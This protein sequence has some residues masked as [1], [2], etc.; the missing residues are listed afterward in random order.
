LAA[1][2]KNKS[3]GPDKVAGKILTLGGE[4]MISCLARLLGVTINKASIPSK[5]KRA[6][7]VPI[8]KRGDRS[9]VKNYRPVSLTGVLRANGTRLALYLRQG[10]RVGGQ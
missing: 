8:Y 3:I 5:W 6:T 7:V 10:V 2:G 4:A 1:G 9:L